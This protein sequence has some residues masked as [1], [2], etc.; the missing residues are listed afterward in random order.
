FLNG[1]RVRVAANLQL[2]ATFEFVDVTV[3]PN[4]NGSPNTIDIPFVQ[5]DDGATLAGVLVANINATLAGFVSA[6]VTGSRITLGG[7]FSASLSNHDP[8]T[9]QIEGSVGIAPVLEIVDPTLIVDGDQ[10]TVTTAAGSQTFEFDDTF[11]STGVAGNNIAIPFNVLQTAEQIA[12]TVAFEVLQSQSV[13]GLN[14]TSQLGGP[15]VAINGPGINQSAG[16]P[17]VLNFVQNPGALAVPPV[18]AIPSEEVF[19]GT[20][21][22]NQNIND[23]TIDFIGRSVEAGVNQDGRFVA[24]HRKNPEANEAV[25]IPSNYGEFS[26]DRISFL[27]AEV[28]DFRGMQATT[29]FPIQAASN[30]PWIDQGTRGGLTDPL[31]VGIE[32]LAADEGQDYTFDQFNLLATF[33]QF[34]SAQM[35]F[36]AFQADPQPGVATKINDVVSATFAELIANQDISVQQTGASIKLIGASPIVSA[37]FN[38][39]GEGPGGLITG[40][41]IMEDSGLSQRGTGGQI[42]AVSDVGGLYTVDIRQ[43]PSELG[44]PGLYEITNVDY[45]ESSA[46]DLLGIRFQGLTHGPADVEGGRY[47][48][49]LFGTDDDGRIYAFDTSGV[50]QPIFL[51]GQTSVA[52][53]LNQVRGLEFGTLDENLFHETRRVPGSEVTDFMDERFIGVAEGSSFVLNERQLNTVGGGLSEAIGH[54][55]PVAFDGQPS[56]A[57]AG[58]SSLHFGRGMYQLPDPN[59][60]TGSQPHLGAISGARGYDFPG[61]AHGSIVT[62][63]FSLVGYRPEDRPTLYFNYFAETDGSGNSDGFR[64]FVSDNDGDWE[65]VASNHGAGQELFDNTGTWRQVRIPLDNFAGVDHLRLRLD[66]STAGDMNLG[67][68]F[69]AGEELRTVAGIY[70]RDGDRFQIDG[71]QFEFDSGYT[72]VP[73][74]G[75]P[76]QDGERLKI[77]DPFGKQVVFE[78]DKDGTYTHSIQ[79]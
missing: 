64:V 24:S 30:R 22:P 76:I 11:G 37:P 56:P 29:T 31:H 70:L 41:V 51:D 63:E 65:L 8:R 43:T 26:Y 53:G 4:A 60:D 13:N 47:R 28:G 75:G 59:G 55:S 10:F 57:R 48:D 79:L 77:Q 40:L 12:T 46:A 27:G 45:I 20:I 72:V 9:I 19:P 17:L 23:L 71:E 3:D 15:R 35:Q 14:L 74:S 52:T 25:L 78:F 32:L 61:G 6:G 69:T 50:L 38:A 5:T 68:T 42:F 21:T 34:G 2:A 7:E 73:T 39:A 58:F 54:G 49:L 67:D 36:G 66:F 1:T 16:S 18:V 44:F 33:P 62:N